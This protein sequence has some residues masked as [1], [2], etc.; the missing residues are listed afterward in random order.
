MFVIIMQ[1]PRRAEKRC[2]SLL[3]WLKGEV[4]F[5]LEPVVDFANG[6]IRA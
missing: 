6:R 4:G 5:M 3:G 1:R 2:S